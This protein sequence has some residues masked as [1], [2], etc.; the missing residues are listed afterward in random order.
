MKYSPYGKVL[1]IKV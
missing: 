1:L